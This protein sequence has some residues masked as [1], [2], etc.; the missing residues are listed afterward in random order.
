MFTTAPLQQTS[1]LFS[2]DDALLNV[3]LFGEG[4]RGVGGIDHHFHQ[5]FRY[6]T[7]AR[8]NGS[9]KHWIVPDQSNLWPLAE[10]SFRLETD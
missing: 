3:C 5:F 1:L 2:L 9:G 10:Q 4:E 6:I 8:P 7:T